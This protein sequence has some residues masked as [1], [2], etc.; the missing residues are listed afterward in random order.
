MSTK[1]TKGTKKYFKEECSEMQGPSL[2]SIVK[3]LT[4]FHFGK[5]YK[6]INLIYVDFTNHILMSLTFLKIKELTFSYSIRKVQVM[7]PSLKVMILN[8]GIQRHL[9]NV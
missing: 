4:C 7:L 2:K 6:G 5:I 9:L 3:W 1:N 8:I